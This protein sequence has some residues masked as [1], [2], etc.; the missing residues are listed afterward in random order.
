MAPTGA[1]GVKKVSSWNQ[2]WPFLTHIPSPWWKSILLY[3]S[4]PN[5]S[6]FEFSDLPDPHLNL[7]WPGPELDNWI[8]HQNVASFEVGFRLIMAFRLLNVYFTYLCT[9]T[10]FIGC[11]YV[12]Y[13]EHWTRIPIWISGRTEM[14]DLIIGCL[15]L[16][17]IFIKYHKN[18]TYLITRYIILS[19]LILI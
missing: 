14:S 15:C 19:Y 8:G 16:F 5:L 6:S 12:M 7:T 9:D 11:M 17:L 1:Q 10:A 2:P 4:G 18:Y 13:I 3:G